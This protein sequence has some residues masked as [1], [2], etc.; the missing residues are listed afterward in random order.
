[1]PG[2]SAAAQVM[3]FDLQGFA[4]SQGSACSSGTMKTSAVLGAMGVEAD[5]AA[6][7]IRVS[8]GWNSTEAEVDAFADAWAAMAGG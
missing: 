4:V 6:R 5:L 8:L 3:R 7:M 2:M 1:M